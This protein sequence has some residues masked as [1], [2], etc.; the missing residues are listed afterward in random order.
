[1]VL[2]DK[3]F[4]AFKYSCKRSHKRI[5]R[6]SLQCVAF[7]CKVFFY[8]LDSD[9]RSFYD[10]L[11][12]RKKRSRS[13]IRLVT[14]S[15]SR[16]RNA[17]FSS[18]IRAR[19]MCTLALPHR[20]RTFAVCGGPETARFSF[21]RRLTIAFVHSACVPSRPPTILQHATCLPEFRSCVPFHALRAFIYSI[22]YVNYR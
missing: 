21:R 4:H 10:A 16:A 17:A 3:V 22:R 20:G 15:L 13:I 7:N 9:D 14:E 5:A 6:Y 1:M 2:L 8:I 18:T 19:K 12:D 11:R